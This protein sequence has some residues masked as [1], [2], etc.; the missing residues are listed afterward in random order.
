M[1][2]QCLIPGGGGDEALK[3]NEG[4]GDARRRILVLGCFAQNAI[5]FSR[6]GLV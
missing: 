3:G 5:I 4:G 6:E 1:T 2:V